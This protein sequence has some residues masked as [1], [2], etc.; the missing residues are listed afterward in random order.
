MIRG[1][2]RI[3]VSERKAVDLSSSPRDKERRGERA[4]VNPLAER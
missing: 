2:P 4:Y 3:E 1:L